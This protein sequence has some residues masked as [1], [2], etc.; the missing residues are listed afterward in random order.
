MQEA[1]YLAKHAA[2]APPGSIDHD[3]DDLA[4]R[5][6]QLPRRGQKY[7]TRWPDLIKR[8][9]GQT[10]RGAVQLAEEYPID[11]ATWGRWA[12]GDVPDAIRPDS[13]RIVAEAANLPE[14]VV[15][16][17]AR[18]H[19]VGVECPIGDVELHMYDQAARANMDE[20][21]IAAL[22]QFMSKRYGNVT[23][24]LMA[25]ASQFIAAWCD[26]RAA[27]RDDAYGRTDQHL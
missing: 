17:I 25:D 14:R 3:A 27:T 8:V 21:G 10:A 6:V 1:G 23:A 13:I 18:Q 11:R 24:G 20:A 9:I 19:H 15:W 12:R 2:A 7:P 16:L 26:L 22:E 5:T 4:D